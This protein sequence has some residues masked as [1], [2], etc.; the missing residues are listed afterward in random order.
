MRVSSEDRSD[1][2]RPR[3]DTPR[4]TSASKR[5]SSV[6]AMRCR[7]KQRPL[8]CLATDTTSP[9]H[10]RTRR[11]PMSANVRLLSSIDRRRFLAHT[12]RGVGAS[13][14]LAL[15][16][17]GRAFA[18]PRLSSNPFTLGVA[19][20]DPTPD[21][22]VLWTRLA[23]EPANLDSLGRSVVPVRLAGR[24]GRR[25]ASRRGGRRRSRSPELAH[26]VHVEV[27]GLRPGRDYFYQFDV[28]RRGEPD[29]P[30][31]YGAGPARDGRTDSL[32][33][34]N[35]PGLAERLLHGVSRHA[36]E[37]SG[38]RAAPG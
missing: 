19:S 7:R 27:E 38:S 13:L 18:A 11:T 33:L 2:V 1:P 32:R 24:Q 8:V 25:H 17:G 29:R 4:R 14:A 3:E 9:P 36:D 28:R 5:H 31:P 21:G 20:G 35:L 15:V 37:R 23:P 12:W 16:P 26:S 10:S 34:R 22:I 6:T 30:L